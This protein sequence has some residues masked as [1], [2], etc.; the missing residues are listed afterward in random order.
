MKILNIPCPHSNEPSRFLARKN[1]PTLMTF[2]QNYHCKLGA[3]T[4]PWNFNPGCDETWAWLSLH[5]DHWHISW[6]KFGVWTSKLKGHGNGHI[7]PMSLRWDEKLRPP[8]WWPDHVVIHQLGY[9]VFL[10]RQPASYLPTYLPTYLKTLN[11][12]TTKL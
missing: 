6:K 5:K 8:K 3:W 10:Q 12:L 9:W 7:I 11:P 2:D 4:W 1:A